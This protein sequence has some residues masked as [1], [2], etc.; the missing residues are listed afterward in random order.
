MDTRHLTRPHQ[1]EDS[2]G[3][4]DPPTTPEVLMYLVRDIF[5]CKPGQVRPLV[6]KFTAVARLG[7]KMGMPPMRIMTDFF[8]EQFWTLV[9]EMEVPSLQAYEEMMSNP[10]ASPEDMK[11]FE[12]MMKGYHDFVDHG[13]REIYKIEG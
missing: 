1:A 8:A 7:E 13:R 10:Q 5:H 9:L 4:R 3:L 6:E 2:P 12:A 11:K